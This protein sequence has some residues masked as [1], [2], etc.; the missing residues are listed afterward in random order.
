MCCQ[1][2]RR[3]SRGWV[4]VISGFVVEADP[5]WEREERRVSWIPGAEGAELM[6]ELEVVRFVVE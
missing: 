1:F 6:D 4:E 5:P 2:A 3:D